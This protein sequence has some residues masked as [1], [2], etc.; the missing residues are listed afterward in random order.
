MSL[1]PTQ[2]T[3]PLPGG[4]MGKILR[5]DLTG[6]TLRDEYLPEEPILKKFIGGQALALYILLKELP[7]NAT[8]FGPENI[9]VIMTGPLTGNGFTPGGTKMTAVY[10]S[11]LTANTLGRGA[12][13]GYW[14]T[15]L[16]A[17][18]YDGIILNGAAVKPVYLYID[19][20]EAELRDA[21]QFWGLGTRATEDR[22]RD[23]VGHQ[24]AKV[25]CIGP[26]G[27]NLNRAA[28]LANDYNHF[29]AHSGGAVLGSKKLKA[30]V[31]HG[32]KRPSHR[33]KAKLVDAGWRWRKLLE[34]H[35]VK[36]K[37]TKYGHG[38]A[39]GALNN[40]NWRSTE[41]SPAHIKGFDQN[42]VVLRPCFQCA[43]LCPWDA[44][45]GEGRH[46]GT[47]LHF[48]A[49]GEWLDTFFNLGIKGNSALYLAERIND[50]GIECSHF[51]CGA[52]V[53]FEAWEKG[54][55]GPEKTNGLKLEWG[56]VD[57]VEKLLDMAARREGWLGNLL[58]EGPKQL[59][60]AIGGDAPKW[61]V[62]TKGGTPAMHEWRPMLGQ[63][64]R[65]LVA[66]GGMKPQG[67]G[68][69]KPPPD[70]RH[71]ENW[72]P[73]SADNPDGWAWSHVLSEQYRQFTGIFGGCWFAQMNQKP[74][75]LNSIVD[76]FNAITGW[77]FTMDEALDAG[78]R[79]MI[80]QSLFGTQ[81]GWIADF[82]WQDVGPRFLEPIPDGKYKGFTIA[83]WLPDMIWEYYRLSGR[84]ERTGRPF[85]DTLD[86]LGL[87]EFTEWSQLD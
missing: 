4:Y 19:E 18:G 84:H 56:D 66:S 21:A 61:A 60:E 37:K 29:A 7:L 87:E 83:K 51:S 41:L 68:S 12:T 73:L 55:L 85:K 17:A 59:A 35:D 78:H 86:K 81:R 24:D 64:L 5:V 26:A 45:I 43:R 63:M 69:T 49:G 46:K 30:I 42:D 71:R 76:A 72:G 3:T 32:T 23:T 58:A 1:F 80:L 6:G 70:L 14:G 39:W 11:P 57:A 33:D 65:E 25:L 13:S 74:D 22:L 52:G 20:G 2:R 10:L 16:K 67:G 53:A 36:K 47:L 79:S 77:N 62:H 75:G 54:L 27:E 8:P 48:N 50:L 40:L 82:D 9:V 28:M 44:T 31:V 38:E 34:Q 15:Y